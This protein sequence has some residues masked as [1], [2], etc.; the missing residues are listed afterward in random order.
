MK[1]IYQ[2]K[3][4]E[5]Y[6]FSCLYTDVDKPYMGNLGVLFEFIRLFQQS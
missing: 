3:Y 2:D 6:Y 5:V 1:I 4:K